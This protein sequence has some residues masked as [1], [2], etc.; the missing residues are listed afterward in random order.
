MSD[1]GFWPGLRGRRKECD[2]LS[3]LVASVQSGRSQVLVL[4]GEA[5]IGKTALLE[6]LV[7]RAEGCRVGRAAGVESELELAY[8]GLHQL[9]RRSSYLDRIGTLPVPQ[10]EALGTV[11][12]LQPGPVPDRFLLG[13]AVLTLLFE[14]AEEQPLICVV[15][16]AQ[17]L[18]QASAQTLEFVARRLAAE[19]VGLVF[20]VRETD[21]EPKLAGLPELRVRGLAIDDAAALLESAVPGTLDSR[22]RDR[23]LAESQ[24][25]PL[26]LLELPRA[27]TPTELAFGTA[28]GARSTAPLASRLEKSFI[29]QLRSLPPPSRQFL[30]VAAAEPVGDVPLLWRAAQR[31]GIGADAATTAEAAGFIEFRDRVR[32][33]H[34]LVRSAVYRSAPAAERREVHQAL[35][36]A[37]DPD[38]D[39]DRRAWHRACA[40]VGPDEQ[41]AAELERSAD[42]SVSLG[43]I[44]AAAA[45]LETAAALTPEPARRARRSLAA[46]QAKATA[47]AFGAAFASSPTP[48]RDRSTKPARPRS[49]C[50]VPR[51]RTTQA[52]ATRRCR[53]SWPPPAGSN[54]W[55]RAWPGRPIWTRCPPRCLP[56]AWPSA[57]ALVVVLASACARWR[58][59]CGRRPRRRRRARPTCCSTGWRCCTPTGTRHRR[60]GC[61]GPC[62]RSAATTSP[63]MK[64]SAARGS[65][66]SQPSTCGTTCTGTS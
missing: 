8:A 9:C 20:A 49:I 63:W 1:G 7:N 65:R 38:L 26:A 47:G 27:L 33:R 52:T 62:R 54:W 24:G 10:R 50:C 61:T 44:A 59:P 53:C 17:W 64:L 34:P 28:P 46:A 11:F 25:N 6:F 48:R 29:T 14:V 36:D 60:P 31:L 58:R 3:G 23:I 42:R 19:P 16:D 5:G 35:A 22:V 45:F 51:S 40:A 13:L 39:P 30:L 56:G 32:F 2:T 18:D 15:D 37:T 4:R 21:K 55:S 12:G 66:P 43:G 57:R 41:V